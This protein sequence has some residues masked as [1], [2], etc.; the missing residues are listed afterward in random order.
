MHTPQRIVVLGARFA[1]LATV[2]WLTRLFDPHEAS[3]TVID[4]SD[5][6]AFR[7]YLV[8][9]MD[10]P[11]SFVDRSIIALGPVFERRRVKLVRDTIVGIDPGRRRV[12]LASHHPIAYDRLFLATGA[13][14]A[15][16]LIDGLSPMDGGL[17]EPYLA[18]HTA[19]LNAEW[20]GGTFL[21]AAGPLV[22]D[23][24]ATPRLGAGYAFPLYEAA[25][26]FEAALRRR[27]RRRDTKLLLA[28]PSAE[29]GEE[30]GPR[31]RAALNALFRER[32]ITVLPNATFVKVRN[33]R[34][35]LADRTLA[36]HRAVWI[37]PCAGSALARASGLDDGYGF[38]P[39]NAYLQHPNWPD[40]YAIGDIV[41]DSLP[42]QAHAAMVQARVAVHHL[43]ARTHQRPVPAPYRPETVLILE[44]GSARGLLSISDTLFGGH[45]EIVWTGH[46]PA[47]AKSAWS[48]AFMLFKGDLPIMP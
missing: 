13:D 19:A 35:H 45:R 5:R 24:N 41:R 21:F 42:K 15:W 31:T 11:P 17:C 46:L 36:Y 34:V 44:T 38:V 7:P 33:N 2:V 39:T 48:R 26:L 40:I 18:R 8:H 25:L 10:R 22:R 4:Q 1:G 28:L 30:A 27:G 47:Y 23:P 6:M 9:A 43:W 32:N 29:A 3:I 37:P 16:S 20:T 12:E 14:P